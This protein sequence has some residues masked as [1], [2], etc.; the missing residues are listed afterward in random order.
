MTSMMS[1]QRLIG[2][3]LVVV[4]AAAFGTLAIFAR[5]A[6]GAGA[7]GVTTLFFR[8]AL[9]ALIMFGVLR[10]R[11]EPLP[12]GRPLLGLIGMGALGYFGQSLCYVTALN[13]APA[14]LVALLLYLYPVFVTGLSAVVLKEPITRGKAVALG[15]AFAGTAL[16]VGPEGGGQWQGLALS[17]L[18]AAIYSVYI[19]VGSQVLKQVTVVQSS[20]VIMASA[21]ASFAVLMLARGPQFPQAPA[22]WW[23]IAAIVGI[24]TILPI[25]TFLA[26]L[27]RIGPTNASMLSTLEPVV[28][29]LLAVLWLGEALRPV[30]LAGGGLILAAVLVLTRVMARGQSG[31]ER[32]GQ[33]A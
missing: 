7:D 23:A 9:S 21:A 30:S 28:T 3:L 12:R 2:I 17:V 15:L 18:A 4:S 11:G 26:G 22:G 31:T 8:F 20:S 10:A 24:S 29:V 27:E 6:T 1:S 13:Y 5:F 14:G 19:L 33:H 32:T 16:T 25:L